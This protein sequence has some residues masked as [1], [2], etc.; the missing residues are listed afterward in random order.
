MSDVSGG[1]IGDKQRLEMGLST[2][3]SEAIDGLGAEVEF[4]ANEAMLPMG[5][6]LEAGCQEAGVARVIG[7]ADEDGLGVGVLGE[8]LWRPVEAQGCGF[9]TLLGFEVMGEDKAGGAAAELGVGGVVEAMPDFRLPEAIEGLD[10][11]LKAVLAGWGEDGGDA[12]SQTEEGDGAEAIGMVMGAVKAQVV[13]ELSVGG[14][15][16]LAPM[17]QQGIAGE[18]G[19]DGGGEE[20]AAKASVQGDNV[21]DLDFAAALDDESLDHIPGIQFGAGGGDVRE[22]PAWRR[23]GTTQATGA[24]DKATALEHV[25]NGGT[26]GQR[27]A[28]RRLGAQGAKDGDRTIFTQGITMAESVAQVEDALD[29]GSGQGVSR[30]MRGVGV[31]REINPVESASARS[32]DPVLHARKGDPELAGDLSQADATAGEEHQLPAITIREFFMLGR[33]AGA[34][35]AAS[36]R[37]APRPAATTTHAARTF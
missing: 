24:F 20:A 2:A 7:A 4:A 33:V 31:V 13:V 21:E 6:D 16:V 15:A 10:L 30:L 19:G 28:G 11:V 17:G 32:C 29:H 12:Q 18:L 14:Q 25:G 27:L 5:I 3:E 22:V 23:W 34:R 9:L 8:A 26:A 1:M 35:R 36:T 37:A